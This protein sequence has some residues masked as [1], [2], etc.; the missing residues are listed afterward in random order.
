MGDRCHTCD[1]CFG[2]GLN[3]IV[4]VL[5]YYIEGCGG[6]L[7]SVV[8]IDIDAMNRSIINMNPGMFIR[9]KGNS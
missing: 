1:L 9:L 4:F 3:T 5:S 7:L 2:A 6:S 8:V